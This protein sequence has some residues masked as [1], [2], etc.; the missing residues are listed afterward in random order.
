MPGR[1]DIYQTFSSP[2]DIIAVES[3]ILLTGNSS[4]SYRFYIKAM[5]KDV[6][7]IPGALVLAALYIAGNI[8]YHRISDTLTAELPQTQAA[9]QRGQVIAESC[10]AC[11]YLDQRT[12]FVGPYLVGIIDR[13]VASSD[14]YDYSDALKKMSGSWTV[15]RLATFL[16]NPQQ[17]APGTKMAL[18]GWSKD[19]INALLLYLGSKK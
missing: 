17:V 5:V 11:H 4:T 3:T 19:D 15:E 12:H 9:I 13:P 10:S 6:T 18:E 2:M 1:V 16:A 8:A 7:L 14:G